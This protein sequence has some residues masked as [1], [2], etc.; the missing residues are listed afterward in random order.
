MTA[1]MTSSKWRAVRSMMSRCPRVTGSNEP[2]Q[3]AVA[4]HCDSPAR[5]GLNPSTS[6]GRSRAYRRSAR[7]H[8]TSHATRSAGAGDPAAARPRRCA[9]SASHPGRRAAQDPA[10]L[11]R[12]RAVRRVEEHEVERAL[13]RRLPVRNEVAAHRLDVR[14]HPGAVAESRRGCAARSRS[15]RARSRSTSTARAAPRESASIA[16]RAVPAYRSSTAAS[17]EAVGAPSAANSD[18]LHAVGRRRAALA[19][20]RDQRSPPADAGDHPEPTTVASPVRVR[21]PSPIDLL[22]SS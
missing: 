15:T 20:R 10:Q 8:V 4:T 5:R 9:P 6:R 18:S 17:V 12:R 7:S 22:L 1:T 14:R 13:G 21:P 2:G 19:L 16:E 3:R 11:G